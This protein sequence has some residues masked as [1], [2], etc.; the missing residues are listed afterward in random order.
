MYAGRTEVRK[1]GW[2]KS[3]EQGESQGLFRIAALQSQR[4]AALGSIQINTPPAF[5]AV[6]VLAVAF[7]AAAIIYLFLGHYTQRATDGAGHARAGIGT[8]DAQCGERG[9]CARRRRASR[10]ARVGGANTRKR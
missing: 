4:R 5:W 8:G 3:E 2:T 10:R 7:V 9:R 6:S 1:S